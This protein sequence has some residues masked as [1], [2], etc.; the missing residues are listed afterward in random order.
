MRTH[1]GLAAGLLIVLATASAFGQTAGPEKSRPATKA[2]TP[3]R[4]PWGDPDLQGTFTN[5]DE[6]GIP[7]ERPTQFE[8]RKID[9]VT[10]AELAR[11]VKQRNEVAVEVAGGIGGAETGA[12]PVHW[13]E[14]YNAKNS[15]PWL[16]VDPADGRL[17]PTT[18]A[19]QARTAAI[20]AAFKAHGESDSAEV[21]SLYDRCITRGVP[22]SMMPVIY[23]NSYQFIQ[24]P[25]YVAIRYEMIH[26]TRIIPLDRRSHVGDAIRTYMGDP[27]GHW[28]GTTLVVETTNF[29]G[30]NAADVAG[31]GSP[32]RGATPNLRVI[33]RFKPV[34]QNVLEWSVTLDDATTWA[35]PWTFAMNL[36]KDEGQGVFEYACH[37]GNYGLTGILSAARAEEQQ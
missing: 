7:L 3:G 6:N 34:G 26:E 16:L 29:N 37:E 27:R 9:D 36:T 4:T 8:G 14:Y 18:P 12:G 35:R 24:A 19:A 21:R 5:K 2:D 28:E 1:T 10:G 25:G 13:Y 31:Y 23:G 20:T 22:G 11:I 17:P 15:R 30:K 32:D 33:E